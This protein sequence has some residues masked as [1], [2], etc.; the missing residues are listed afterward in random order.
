[1]SVHAIFAPRPGCPAGGVHGFNTENIKI[2][3]GGAPSFEREPQLGDPIAVPSDPHAVAAGLQSF[4][5]YRK[6]VHL[7]REAHLF[8]DP[9]WM[10]GARP[11]L[12]HYA[13]GYGEFAQNPMPFKRAATHFQL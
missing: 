9:K 7:D 12:N 13:L 3:Q 2:A 10:P 4:A 11:M 5:Q 1:M 6:E 8:T